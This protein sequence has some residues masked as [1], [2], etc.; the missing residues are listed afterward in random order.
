M[1]SMATIVLQMLAWLVFLVGTL[2]LGVWLRSHPSVT[3]VQSATKS[4][5][6]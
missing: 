6:R 5:Y 3:V 2:T 1:F 4:S